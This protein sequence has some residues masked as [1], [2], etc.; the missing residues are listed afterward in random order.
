MESHLANFTAVKTGTPNTHPGMKTIL[1]NYILARPGWNVSSERD[2]IL[3]YNQKF[4]LLIS[5]FY[6][7]DE[8]FLFLDTIK[9]LIKAELINKLAD[10]YSNGI[11]KD[12]NI[13]ELVKNIDEYFAAEDWMIPF[14]RERI[15]DK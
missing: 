15:D 5:I 14:I 3:I 11:S 1:S 8:Y 9:T 6:F 12:E 2:D 10:D 7:K 13:G 4:P